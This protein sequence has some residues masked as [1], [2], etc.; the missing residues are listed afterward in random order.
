MKEVYKLFAATVEVVDRFEHGPLQVQ[1]E[2]NSENL[3]MGPT[4]CVQF[5]QFRE[6]NQGA[7]DNRRARR[8]TFILD[9]KSTTSCD[10]EE[11]KMKLNLQPNSKGAL[12]YRGRIQGQYPVLPYSHLYIQRLVEKAH[13]Q[14]L[15]GGAGLT[16]GLTLICH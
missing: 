9:K 8:A 16:M 11:N 5:S 4:I 13:S 10:V 12:E 7:I 2:Q 1:S 14:T 15:H 3:C 6:Q